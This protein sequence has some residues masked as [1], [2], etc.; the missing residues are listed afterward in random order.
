[1]P[2][3]LPPFLGGSLAILLIWLAVGLQ[4]LRAHRQDWAR[5]LA[6]EIRRWDGRLPDDLNRGAHP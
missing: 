2:R 3:W 5:R 4:R 1:M 6:H